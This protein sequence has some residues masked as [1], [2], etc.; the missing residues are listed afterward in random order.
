MPS[1]TPSRISFLAVVSLLIGA[2]SL[3]MLG[4]GG[5]GLVAALIGWLA[6]RHINTSEG[7]LRGQSVAAAGIVLGLAAVAVTIIG[8]LSSIVLRTWESSH[9]MECLNNLRRI[10]LAANR[11]YD[12]SKDSAADEAHYPQAA[13]P[14][15]SLPPARRL[16]WLVELLPHLDTA[17]GPRRGPAAVAERIDLRQAWDAP[18]NHE[19]AQTN[20]RQFICPSHPSY[21]MR[22]HPGRNY[23]VGIAGINP[24]AAFLPRSSP[25]AGAL[26]FDR[27]IRPEDVPAGASYTLLAVET[28][29]DIGAWI[30]AGE[31]TLHG[32]NPDQDSYLGGGK[33]FGG[34]HPHGANAVFLDGSARF[35]ADGISAKLW[36][37][38]STLSGG[39]S[40]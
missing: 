21:D 18:A 5:T 19:V 1:A 7:R 9:R 39:E 17:A 15:N 30:A 24:D 38:M 3:A 4:L 20:L 36:R 31:P 6:I 22:E 27:R 23:Y 14:N 10:G 11:Y 13:V 32:V 40:P 26:G 8:F 16:S 2:V 35:I 34:L 12:L 29:R 37:G 25:R 28:T 33:P